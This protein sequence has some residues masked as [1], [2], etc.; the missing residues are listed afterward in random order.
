MIV[1]TH[2]GAGVK[3]PYV[4]NQWPPR[5]TPLVMRVFSTYAVSFSDTRTADSNTQMVIG[6][7]L[8]SDDQHKRPAMTPLRSVATP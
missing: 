3:I 2:H 6:G 4:G 7:T 8:M 1:G 5:S